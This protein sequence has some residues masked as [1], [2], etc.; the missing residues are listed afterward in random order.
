MK[1]SYTATIREKA[2]VSTVIPSP[3][4]LLLVFTLSGYGNFSIWHKDA[5]LHCIDL[6][7][8]FYD[9]NMFSYNIPEFIDEKVV[10]KGRD[11]ADFASDSR[12]VSLKYREY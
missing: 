9:S 4:G 7:M 6:H 2:I 10:L 12:S 5:D 8:D 11:V 1:I 3:D